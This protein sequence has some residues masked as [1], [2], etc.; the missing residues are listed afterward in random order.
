[1]RVTRVWVNS[2]TDEIYKFR[3]LKGLLKIIEQDNFLM[4]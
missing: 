2:V 3:T 1:M 4:G